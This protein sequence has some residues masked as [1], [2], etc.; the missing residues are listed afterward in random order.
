MIE[1]GGRSRWWALMRHICSQ[2]KFSDLV[3]LICLGDV[4]VNGMNNLSMEGNKKIW[5]ITGM[6]ELRERMEV[7]TRKVGA[8]DE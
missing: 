1:I 8:S 7:I 5:A 2:E 6:Q 4:S 3:N